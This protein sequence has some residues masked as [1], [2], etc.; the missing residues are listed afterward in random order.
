MT[1]LEEQSYLSWRLSFMKQGGEGEWSVSF[2]LSLPQGKGDACSRAV[3]YSF[4][5]PIASAS[6]PNQARHFP[7][8]YRRFAKQRTSES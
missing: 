5:I 2:K 8:V 4:R 7:V 3:P 6:F 1:Q